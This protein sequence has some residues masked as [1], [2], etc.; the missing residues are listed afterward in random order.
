MWKCGDDEISPQS[1][2]GTEG[3]DYFMKYGNVRFR[4]VHFRGGKE[5][6]KIDPNRDCVLRS[7]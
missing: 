2:E 6:R 3:G 4:V 5:S 1:N 7:N